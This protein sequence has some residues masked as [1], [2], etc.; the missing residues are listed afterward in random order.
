MRRQN[1]ILFVASV[2]A[3]AMIACQVAGKATRDALFLSYFP[4]NW[5][6]FIAIIASLLSIAVGFLT[7][8]LM[9]AVAPSLLIP[10]LFFLSSILHLIEWWIIGWNSSTAAILIYLQI[11]I[12]GSALISGF[13]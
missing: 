10:R 13:W 11:A 7:A 8:R 1:S 3:A 9:T 12:L 5:L 4:V 2:G 6:P